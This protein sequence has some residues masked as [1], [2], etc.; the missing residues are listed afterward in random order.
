[1]LR[2]LLNCENERVQSIARTFVPDK[3]EVPGNTDSKR[4]VTTFKCHPNEPLMHCVP[5]SIA[6]DG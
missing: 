2:E 6:F 1:M 4:P 5:T 3:G